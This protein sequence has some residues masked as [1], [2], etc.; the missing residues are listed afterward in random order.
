MSKC[1][2]SYIIPY[3]KSSEDRDRNMSLTLR[4]LSTHFSHYEVIIVEL[5]SAPKLNKELL[6]PDAKYVFQCNDGIFSRSLAR[7]IGALS[8]SHDILV[9]ADN[10]LIMNP[11]G[12]DFCIEQCCENYEAVNPFCV[13]LDLSEEE[14]GQLDIERNGL[15]ALYK[16]N[17]SP[18]INDT[19]CHRYAPTF[20]GGIM[21]IRKNALFHIGGWPEE[22][23]G[24]G[25]EDNTISYKIERFLGKKS[26]SNYIYHLPHERL[27]YDWNSHPEFKNNCEKMNNVFDMT[28]NELILYCENSKKKILSYQS[29][30]FTSEYTN[31]LL[32][33]KLPYPKPKPN[34]MG[35]TFL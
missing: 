24:W 10:D 3:R 23:I 7:N 31:A 20:A 26:Y 29:N 19:D 8:A 14:L 15:E 34:D 6:P 2:V 16:S 13:Y 9:F 21:I 12:F 30:S 4:W 1:K 17:E 18:K 35:F 5:D 28:D 25:A 33:Y 32:A 11:E 27:V 22:M